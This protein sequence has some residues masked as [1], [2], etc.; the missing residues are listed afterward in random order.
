ME[1]DNKFIRFLRAAWEYIKQARMELLILAGVLVLDLGSK[2]IVDAVMDEYDP[3]VTLIPKFLHINYIHNPAAAFGSSFGLDKVLGQK[4]V[5][6]LFIVISFVAVGFFSY[7]MYRSRGKSKFSRV[8]YALIIGGAIGNLVDRLA[9]GY[10][11]DFIQF[12]YFGLTIF[13]SEYFAIFNFADSALCIG[14]VLFAVYYIF[15]YKEPK[16]AVA[17]TEAEEASESGDDAAAEDSAGGP[18]VSSESVAVSGG[19]AS[20]KDSASVETVKTGEGTES[21]NNEKDG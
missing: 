14:V 12:Q 19:N 4:G 11:R 10:V 5:M 3:P 13:G 16:K 21:L 6:I 9:F 2:A 1:K 17:E 7:F 20:V 8:A 15:I 18:S